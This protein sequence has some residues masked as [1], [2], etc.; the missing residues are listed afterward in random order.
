MRS[1]K[2]PP[3][4]TLFSGDTERYKSYGHDD[5]P[6][7]EQADTSM[8]SPN[9]DMNNLDKTKRILALDLPV[10]EDGKH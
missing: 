10:S 1:K 4:K 8:R 5:T 7:N 3:E 9:G 6:M 2:S